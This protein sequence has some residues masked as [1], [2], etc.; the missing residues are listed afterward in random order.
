MAFTLEDKNII[1]LL[2]HTKGCSAK[3]LLKMFSH[4]QWTLGGLDHLSTTAFCLSKQ[5]YNIFVFHC[6]S[7]FV[8]NK[9]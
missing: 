1:K 9:L 2:I 4:K 7:H 8:N 3:Q 6:E 5:F